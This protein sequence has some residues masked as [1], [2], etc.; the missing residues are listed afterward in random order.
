MDILK[1]LD[2]KT[3]LVISKGMRIPYNVGTILIYGEYKIELLGILNDVEK[4]IFNSKIH[5]R[6]FYT[7][8]LNLQDDASIEMKYL[9]T[10]RKVKHYI[11]SIGNKKYLNTGCTV[12]DLDDIKYFKKR[13]WLDLNFIR[14]W[15]EMLSYEEE[16]TEKIA[17]VRYNIIEK[18]LEEG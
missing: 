13:N 18:A 9:C 6:N 14:V 1:V 8:Y 11:V 12:F 7:H 5:I 17:K 2:S 15:Q 10:L 3:K 4:D 16:N